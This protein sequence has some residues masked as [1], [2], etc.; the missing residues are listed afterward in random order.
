MSGLEVR[1]KREVKITPDAAETWLRGASC[2]E[3]LFSSFIP[4]TQAA[5]LS[6]SEESVKRNASAAAGVTLI[7]MLLTMMVTTPA[8]AFASAWSSA[9]T[10]GLIVVPSFVMGGAVG[11]ATW[12]SAK[13]NQ[14][15]WGVV[16]DIQTAGLQLWLEHRYRINASEK[17]L[18]NAAEYALIDNIISPLEGVDF[19]DIDGRIW[20]LTAVHFS[21]PGKTLWQVTEKEP[22]LQEIAEQGAI[23]APATVSTLPVDARVLHEQVVS[24]IQTL[25]AF[26]LPVEASHVVQRAVQETDEAVNSYRQ[27]ERL[28]QAEAGYTELVEV[29]AAVKADLQQVVDQE[30]AVVKKRLVVQSQFLRDGQDRVAGL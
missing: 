9:L 23:K 10:L 12:V 30:V 2:G 28:G 7:G 17:A 25:T 29:L 24:Q 20:R 16:K 6:E 22:E 4:F 3:E 1:A 11:Y 5:K 26:T 19:K 8:D 18:S 15:L 13:R 21:N 27:L 14:G